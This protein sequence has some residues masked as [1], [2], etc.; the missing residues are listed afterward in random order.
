MERLALWNNELTGEIPAELGNLSKLQ[1]FGL[2]HNSL[3]GQIPSELGDL[4]NL[5]ELYLNGNR[6]TGQIPAQLESLT[7][8]ERLYISGNVFSGC[9]PEGLRDVA[10]N[11][12]YRLNLPFCDDVE[13]S[14][15]S[16]GTAVPDP[17][18]N[19]GLV[20]DCNALIASRDT[21]AATAT[22]NWSSDTLMTDWDG[23]TLRGTPARVAWL[24][25]RD[26]GLRGSVPAELGHLSHLTYLNLRNNGLSGPLP[27]EL[28]NLTNLRYLGLNNN[29]LSASD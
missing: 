15:C 21:L 23:I 17:A 5:Q 18:N 9:I 14:V 20:S 16:T 6:L 27:T 8:L 28:G 11:D 13:P 1:V 19:P 2:A 22:L 7:N 3:S 24:N 26:A 25:I 4:A 12:F 10:K 29:E